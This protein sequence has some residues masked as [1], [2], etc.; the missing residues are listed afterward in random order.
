MEKVGGTEGGGFKACLKCTQSCFN[1][2]RNGNLPT[3]LYF[4][5]VM[6]GDF[7]TVLQ[8][9]PAFVRL[10]RYQVP[11]DAF[12]EGPSGQVWLVTVHCT[13]TGMAFEQGWQ[14]FVSDHSLD[15]GDFLV[16][17]YA[18]KSH[19]MVQIFGRS[20][21]E[22]RDAFNVRK[23]RTYCMNDRT[24]KR[25]DS[26]RGNTHMENFCSLP[27]KT[28]ISL[29]HNDKNEEDDEVQVLETAPNTT[30]MGDS[31]MQ[32][33]STRTKP[34]IYSGYNSDTLC[35]YL[36]SED[37]VGIKENI[38]KLG[39]STTNYL[40][41]EKEAGIPIH[42]RIVIDSEEES[43]QRTLTADDSK[44]SVGEADSSPTNVVSRHKPLR[45]AVQLVKDVKTAKQ[46]HHAAK[47][48]GKKYVSTHYV[49]RRRPVTQTEREKALE[50]AQSF[51]SRKPFA[52]LT[53]KQSQVYQGFWLSLSAGFSKRCLPDARLQ[54]TLV[55][56][57]EKK[58][59]VCYLGNRRNPGLSGGWKRFTL[60]NNLE[61]GDVCIFEMDNVENYTLKVHI[62]RVVENCIPLKRV[63]GTR[64]NAKTGE[65]KNQS[66]TVKRPSY[67][68]KVQNILEPTPLHVYKTGEPQ[69]KANLGFRTVT[70]D[71]ITKVPKTEPKLCRHVPDVNLMD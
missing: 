50:A 59:T 61:E 9:P 16:F 68:E 47:D 21:C 63:R 30:F 71:V 43:L 11:K 55:G 31:S 35:N 32:M 40:Q 20:G 49:S 62:F 58:W 10:L 17:K 1:T 37:T 36:K 24:E 66:V 14:T 52:L 44:M 42:Q 27:D 23:S 29:A 34:R 51:K 56:P 15:I 39:L 26:R 57:S 5:K 41:V 12:L 7:Q 60:D 67:S 4:F 28:G 8:I 25:Q 48:E 46:T 18:G 70:N 53:M 33:N 65:T 3:P 22:K 69:A 64:S 45:H 54:L 6:L 2:H 13:S 38:V 19:F